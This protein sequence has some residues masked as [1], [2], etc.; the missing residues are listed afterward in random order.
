MCSIF[1]LKRRITNEQDSKN[2]CTGNEQDRVVEDYNVIERYEGFVL[3]E[4]KGKLMD[5]LLKKIPV[6]GHYRSIHA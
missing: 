3:A 4:V 1:I 2:F 5:Q 6:G